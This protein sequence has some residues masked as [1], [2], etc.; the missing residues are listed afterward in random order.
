MLFIVTPALA[1]FDM[2]VQL[3][4]SLD[5]RWF[6]CVSV[7]THPIIHPAHPQSRKPYITV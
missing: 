5:V 3:S 6:V 4:V 7:N 1:W 2:E